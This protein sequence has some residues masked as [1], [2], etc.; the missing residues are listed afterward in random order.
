MSSYP[1]GW[2]PDAQGVTRYWDG[3]QWTEHT[4]PGQPQ[5]PQQPQP[6]GYPAPPAA[7]VGPGTGLPAF[8]FLVVAAVVMALGGILPWFSGF[9]ITKWGIE[10]DGPIILIAAIAAAGLGW[11]TVRRGVAMN[12]VVPLICGVVALIVAIIDYADI[13]DSIFDP[14][15]GIYLAL[16][17]SALMVAASIW[18]I[19]AL[20]ST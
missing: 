7:S 3:T 17:G 1:P 20:R 18:L 8:R 2:Y 13:K 10:R 9:G 12:A 11:V 6:P 5:A 16:V 4:Q 14:S 19:A 15:V